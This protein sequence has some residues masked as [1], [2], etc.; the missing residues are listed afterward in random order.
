MEFVVHTKHL[1][2]IYLYYF[3]L[4][5]IYLL[6]SVDGAVDA[7]VG[8]L[9]SHHQG[10]CGAHRKGVAELRTQIRA[11]Y[12]LLLFLFINFIL[13]FIQIILLVK[14]CLVIAQL[15]RLVIYK[16]VYLYRLYSHLK[17]AIVNKNNVCNVSHKVKTHRKVAIWCLECE[18]KSYKQSQG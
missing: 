12:Y 1:F 9:L 7:D 11:G 18:L 6:H 8:R 5:F 17:L 3:I 2:I 4:L 13:F 14:L 15:I 10:L 16:F